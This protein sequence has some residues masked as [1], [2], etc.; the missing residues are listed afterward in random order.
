MSDLDMNIKIE[1]IKQ[2][3]R[4]QD[5]CEKA[6][7]TQTTLSRIEAGKYLPSITTLV[8]L[9]DALNTSTDKLLGRE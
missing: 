5:L 4:Q 7:I 1:R 9:A 2:G 3:L 8:A 6:N